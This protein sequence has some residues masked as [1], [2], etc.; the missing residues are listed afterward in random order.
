[1]NPSGIIVNTYP[2]TS[3]SQYYG[4][5]LTINGQEAVFFSG[6]ANNANVYL[7]NTVYKPG[8]FV[9]MG[10]G[11]Y[12]PAF[13]YTNKISGKVYMLELVGNTFYTEEM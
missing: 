11:A 6:D 3:V 1:M 2:G 7:G 5:T 4:R 12:H 10:G 9:A 8:R 13:V